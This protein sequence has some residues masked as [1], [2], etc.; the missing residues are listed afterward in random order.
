MPEPG[1]PVARPRRKPAPAPLPNGNGHVPP[2]SDAERRLKDAIDEL[3][4]AARALHLP[5]LRIEWER[6]EGDPSDPRTAEQKAVME[7]TAS[8]LADVQAFHDGPIT[9]PISEVSPPADEDP[10]L[11]SG[12][13]RPGTTIMLTGPPGSSKSW[14]S[15]QLGITCAAGLPAFL[16]RY[17]IPQPLKVLV[18][19]EDNGADEEWRREE[20]ILAQLGLQRSA[21]GDYRRMSLEGLM[22]DQESWQRWLRGHVR[23]HATD[24][25][26]LDP[27]SEM[28]GGKELREDPGFR[29]MLAF[30]KRLKV[31]FPH[32]ATVLVHHTRKTDTKQRGAPKSLDEVRGQ[33]GQ[34]PDVV[35]IMWPL[36]EQ[37]IHWE[38]HKRVPHSKL[39]LEALPTGPLRTVEDL[40]TTRD[41]RME[42]DDRVLAA[43]E[44]G[45]ESADEIVKGS[46]LSR[47]GVYKALR[48]LAEAGR[49]TRRA[50]YRLLIDRTD[51]PIEMAPWEPEEPPEEED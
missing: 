16:P 1:S 28:H 6:S 18:I 49:V 32:L 30:L 15:R 21:L 43:L 41:R 9:W 12:F 2:P 36:G 29:S 13:I 37:R 33:W 35:A 14:A 42:T 17:A 40:S 26:I 38:L 19:D 20:A 39:V 44:A 47:P 46:G 4:G 24:L 11:V 45:A 23:V 31:D 27:I 7:A 48:R 34:T 50:P 25:L 51:D 5:R 8:F 10:F 22:L 3:H